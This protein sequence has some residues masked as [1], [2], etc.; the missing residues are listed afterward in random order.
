[1]PNVLVRDLPGEVHAE[2]TRR[3]QARGQSLQ[4]FL[5]AELTQLA[6]RPTLDSVFARVSQHTGGRVGLDEAV[7]D[8]AA[9][10]RR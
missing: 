10:R 7:E 5:V 2:L 8:I 6:T 9:D 4:Q 1:M 3:A